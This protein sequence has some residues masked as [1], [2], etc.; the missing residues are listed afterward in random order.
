MIYENEKLSYLVRE[1]EKIINSLFY[2]KNKIFNPKYL[3]VTRR[4]GIKNK[5]FFFLLLLN[6]NLI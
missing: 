4:K 2:E 1:R 5:S 3:I 6:F